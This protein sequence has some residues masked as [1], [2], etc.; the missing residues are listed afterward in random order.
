MASQTISY[1]EVWQKVYQAFNQINFTAFDYYSIKQAL[2]EYMKVYFPESFNDFIESS[3]FIMLV[4]TFA[5][6][7][8][9]LI[10]RVD[11]GSHENFITVAQRKQSVLRLAKLISYTATRNL[12]ARGTL[13]LQSVQTTQVVYDSRGNALNGTTINWND[14]NNNLWFDQF[15]TVMNA[16]SQSAYGTVAPADRVQ[17][18]NTLYELYTLNN[19][20]TTNGVLP[21]NVSVNGT[22]YNMEAVSSAMTANGPVEA[23]PS[24]NSSFSYLYGTDGFGYDSPGTGFFILAK[25][26]SLSSTRTTFDGI[27]PNQTYD[28]SVNNINDID[29][30]LNNVD[31]DTDAILNNGSIGQALS[32]EWCEV[33]TT[34]AQN[35]IFSYSQNRNRYEVETLENDQIRLAFGDGTFCNIPSGTFDIWYRV[36]ANADFSIPQNAITN[37]TFSMSYVDSTGNTQTLQFT[38]SLTT[39]VTNASASETIDHIRENAPNVYYT[40]NRMVNGADYNVF[41]G[42]DPTVLNVMTMNRTF[43]GDSKYSWWYDASGAYENVKIFGNDLIVLFENITANQTVVGTVTTATLFA[44]YITPILSSDIMYNYMVVNKVTSP[45]RSFTTTEQTQIT[46]MLASNSWPDPV[47]LYYDPSQDL[48]K[49]STILSGTPYI[50]ITAVMSGSVVQSWLISNIGYNLVVQSPTTKFWDANDDSLISYETLSPTR[51]QII[52]LQANINNQGTGLIS[53]NLELLVDGIYI[54]TDGLPDITKLNVTSYDAITSNNSGQSIVTQL[55]DPN[56]TFTVPQQAPYTLTLPFNYVVGI[57]EVTVT[58]ILESFWEEDPNTP[59]GGVSNVIVINALTTGPITVYHNSWV[60]YNRTDPSQDWT[61]IAYSTGTAESYALQILGDTPASTALY[62]RERGVPNLNFLWMHQTP[63]YYLVNPS[64]TNIQDVYI[65]Q[66][67]YY[68]EFQQWLAGT[69]S[70]PTPPTPLQL[71]SDYSDL[72]VNAMISDTVV[73]HSGTL[74]PIIG[75]LAIPQ[76]QAQLVVV[77]NPN[78]TLTESQ[79]QLNIVSIVQDYFDIDDWDYGETFY[80][81]QLAATIHQQMPADIS[82]VVLVPL[83]PENYFGDMFEVNMDVDE[84]VQ[85]D[86]GIE[87]IVIVQNLNAVNL[88]QG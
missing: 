56:W 87:D 22:S 86:I 19:R 59:V 43:V 53:G 50:T 57:D 60:Y 24:Y 6:I 11:V 36:S 45:R 78:S 15:I 7:G 39:N 26:G 14:I 42:Q 58:G 8:E 85:V 51:D 84:I 31:P 18:D 62:M 64:M 4:E 48:W 44:N 5:Y 2:V 13:K 80:F 34:T 65:I 77:Q 71:R 83:Y 66:K 61:Y 41:F 68:Q 70:E 25:Q 29:V 37:Q 16:A 46:N 74:K 54:D 38:A 47:Y 63:D 23:R 76:L 49:S 69:A 17:V 79:V 10:Y 30:W 20:Y 3:E 33:D 35:V 81:T 27:T 1:A 67:G 55:I 75:S 73:I 32:G 9:Q 72:L 88:R 28:V 52:L 82:T 21:F 40:Q 12:P